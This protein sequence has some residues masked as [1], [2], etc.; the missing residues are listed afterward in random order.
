[1]AFFIDLG[2]THNQLNPSKRQC[3]VTE[4]GVNTEDRFHFVMG[5]E[6]AL[7][8]D[9]APIIVFPRPFGAAKLLS[10]SLRI[11]APKSSTFLNDTLHPETLLSDSALVIKP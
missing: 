5:V 10:S 7:S 6:S 4:L 9:W 8:C 1:M 2:R 3:H 11:S